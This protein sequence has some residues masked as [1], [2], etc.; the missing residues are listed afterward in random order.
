[1]DV[2]DE[3]V[4]LATMLDDMLEPEAV[5]D[6]R[7]ELVADALVEDRDSRGRFR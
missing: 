6:G 5:V 4:P 1:M 2:V 7:E 3:D